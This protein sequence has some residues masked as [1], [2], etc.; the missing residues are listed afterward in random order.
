[1]EKVRLLPASISLNLAAQFAKV[2]PV[3]VLPLV[4]AVANVG[5]PKASDQLP[6]G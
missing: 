3:P 5:P 4:D 6:L 2:M 1:M